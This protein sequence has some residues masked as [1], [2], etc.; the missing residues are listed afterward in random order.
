M[1]KLIVDTGERLRLA[2][3]IFPFARDHRRR[4][5]QKKTQ[6]MPAACRNCNEFSAT[7]GDHEQ[8][9]TV[10]SLLGCERMPSKRYRPWGIDD[11]RFAGGAAPP[12]RARNFAAM[13]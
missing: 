13:T 3:L 7:A 4:L 1:R 5:L 2:S 9:V 11:Q 8:Y 10:R 12:Y 6:Y